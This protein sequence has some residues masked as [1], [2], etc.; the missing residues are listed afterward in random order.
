MGKIEYRSTNL[1]IQSILEELIKVDRQP[2][3]LRK[4]IVKTHL[5]RT[6]G[7]KLATA[8]KYLEKMENAEYITSSSELWG[9]RP[10]IIYNITPKGKT[11]YEWFVKINSEL[12]IDSNKRS[13]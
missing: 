10:I 1:I 8:E 4:G 5:V 3:N 7:L 9:E 6:C 12:E 2:S 13:Q 11:R